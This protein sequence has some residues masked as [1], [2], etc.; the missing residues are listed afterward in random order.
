MTAWQ[1]AEAERDRRLTWLTAMACSSSSGPTRAKNAAREDYDIVKDLHA[2][3]AVGTY[4]AAV[5]TKD[6]EGQGARQQGRD[7]DAARRVGRCGCRCGRR[8]A[9]RASGAR[10]RARRGRAS[11][12]WA[13][14][15]AKGISRSD[16][17]EL[18]D[19]IDSGEA[20]LLVI[21]EST[22]EAG[23]RQGNAEGREAGRQAARREHGRRGRRGQGGRGRSQ[24]IGLA[25]AGWADRGK[26]VQDARKIAHPRRRGT[27]SREGKARAKGVAPAGT[28]PGMDAG[29]RPAR[30]GRVARGAERHP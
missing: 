2:L 1:V 8:H 18:G 19:L 13:A 29:R 3:D 9:L 24:L 26:S 4:D 15:Y 5:I 16:V 17:K 10:H 14:T 20:A 27:E 23:A 28:T 22:L 6:E 12:R 7:G 30:P 25:G 11:A 21:G